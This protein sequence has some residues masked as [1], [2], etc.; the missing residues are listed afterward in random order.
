MP[1]LIEK[2]AKHHTFMFSKILYFVKSDTIHFV[3]IQSKL[4]FKKKQTG[5]T[6][7]KPN[8]IRHNPFCTNKYNITYPNSKLEYLQL[9]EYFLFS[10]A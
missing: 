9:F 7:T 2:C 3:N 8:S 6:Q 10:V 5:V 1:T 4:K